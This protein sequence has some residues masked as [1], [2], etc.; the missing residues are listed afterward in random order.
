MGMAM[1]EVREQLSELV[2]RAKYQGEQIT[3]GPHRGDDVTLVST[4]RLR[5]L[6]ARVREAEARLAQLGSTSLA[7]EAPFAGLQRALESG[8]LSTQRNG[9]RERRVL[10]DSAVEVPLSREARIRLGAQDRR[11]PTYRRTLPRA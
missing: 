8:V 9:S 3:F 2:K 7:G 11:T 1:K 4:E 10:A 5:E 6:E